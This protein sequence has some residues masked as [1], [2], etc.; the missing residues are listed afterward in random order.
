M[1]RWSTPRG[2]A[3]AGQRQASLQR[4]LLALQD[5]ALPPAGVDLNAL[6][7]L[8][9]EQLGQ[10]TQVWSELGLERRRQLLAALVEFAESHVDACF[11]P[12]CRWLLDDADPLIRT[13]AIE[14][15]WEE[16]DVRLI[17]PLI[18][19]LEQDL[20]P[21]VRAA[22]AASL[23]RYLLL[24]EYDQIDASAA[25]RVERALV[26]AHQMED[27]DVW[28]R[29]RTLEALANGSASEL[30]QMIRAAYQEADEILRI[31]AVF[32]M[33]RSADPQ[34]NRSVLAE[35]NAEES[36]MLFEAVRASGEL[37]I[38]E[39]TPE[40]IRLL[41]DEDIEIRDA[42]VWALGR[43]GGR[44]AWRALKA[45]SSSADESLAEAAQDALAEL[46]FLA[47]DDAM[48]GLFFQA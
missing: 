19:R 7:D 44:E 41:G 22:A 42:A 23:G 26:A 36:A 37:E 38:E 18:R 21:E 6:S 46:A 15:L 5:P 32:A 12:I 33:G 40:L 14:G 17:S 8:N 10:F 9:R 43:I 34:W 48:P 31:G 20:H 35:L 25:H 47:G 2:Q 13:Q 3:V 28:V 29:R 16:E 27:E 4:T 30:T 1:D 45:C 24:G 11:T 39:A